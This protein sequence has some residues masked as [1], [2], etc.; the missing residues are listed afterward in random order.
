MLAS[1]GSSR[2]AVW[3][4]S[5]RAIKTTS[6][7]ENNE[8]RQTAAAFFSSMPMFLYS[9]NFLMSSGESTL[10]DDFTSPSITKAG[11]IITPKLII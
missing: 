7:A 8:I 4:S 11:V 10:P 5:E 1:C 6:V 3:Q 2:E 9:S